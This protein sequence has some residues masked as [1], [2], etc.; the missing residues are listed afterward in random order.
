[1]LRTPHRRLPPALRITGQV[2]FALASLALP[3]TL[4]AQDAAAPATET[5]APPTIS[6]KQSRE[7]DDAYLAGA[8]E[9]T[10][11]NP[12]A[13]ERNFGRAL[14]LDP[15]KPEYALSLAVA[16]K[17]HHVTRA[18]SSRARE[19]HALPGHNAIQADRLFAESKNSRS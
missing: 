12:A 17:E 7:A 6:A 5:K 15:S 1:M 4:H 10:H 16:T 19:K 18:H 13:A 8:R 11:N 9:L 14:A 2:A 3:H